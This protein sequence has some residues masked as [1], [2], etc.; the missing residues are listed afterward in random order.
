MTFS[1]PSPGLCGIL[2]AVADSYLALRLAGYPAA[3][4]SR[5]VT[6]EFS[7][8]HALEL[9]RRRPEQLRRALAEWMPYTRP[10]EE[11]DDL[12]PGY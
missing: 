4:A 11:S 7:T 2:D 10:K 1:N 8:R 5:I 9:E 12:H 6:Q 3:T